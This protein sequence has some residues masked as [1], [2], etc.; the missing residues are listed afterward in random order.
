M[1]PPPGG[2]AYPVFR[3]ARGLGRGVRLDRCGEIW[4]PDLECAGIAGGVAVG[5]RDGDILLV[6][7]LPV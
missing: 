4:C 7:G 1:L 6:P 2:G 3:V 5:R